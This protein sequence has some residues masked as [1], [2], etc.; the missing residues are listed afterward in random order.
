VPGLR[1]VGVGLIDL[2]AQGGL[3][4]ARIDANDRDPAC[5]QGQRQEVRRQSRLKPSSDEMWRVLTDCPDQ[6]I[7][8]GGAL[9]T[10]YDRTLLI[11][12]TD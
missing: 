12:H 1:I 8:V 5:A 2:H 10:P 9:A 3:G 11:N 4:V 6:D 7:G